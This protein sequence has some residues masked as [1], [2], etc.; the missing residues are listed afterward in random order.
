MRTIEQRRRKR[1]LAR[2][3]MFAT[4]RAFLRLQGSG[5]SSP[6][7]RIRGVALSGLATLGVLAGALAVT[8]A[9]ALAAPEAPVTEAATGETASAATL[10]GELNPLL[11]AETGWHFLYSTEPACTGGTETPAHGVAKVKAKTKEEVE[12]TGLQP[13]KTYSFCLVATNAAAESTEGNSVSFATAGVEPAL[14]GERATFGLLGPL[15]ASLE[16][17]I[18]PE[19]QET[20]YKF[21]YEAEDPTLAGTP[22]TTGEAIISPNIFEEQTAGPSDIGGGLAPNTTYYYRVVAT[23]GTGETKGPIHHF[24]TLNQEAPITRQATSI[25][26]TSAIL[27][28]ELNPGG[29]GTAAYDFSYNAGGSCEGGSTTTP[30]ETTGTAVKVSQLVALEGNTEYT[31]CL[32]GF[33]A[34]ETTETISGGS[35][36]FF[37]PKIAPEVLGESSEGVT[38]FAATLKAEVNPENQPTT[39][40]VFEYGKVVSEHSAPCSPSSVEGS[41]PQPVTASLGGLE[42]ATTYHYRVVTGNPTGKATGVK[43][44]EFKTLPTEAPTVGN[45]HA[46]EETPFAAT[47]NAEV[48]PEYQKTSCEI[49]WG[50]V[51]SEHTEKCVPPTLEGSGN[52]GVSLPVKGLKPGTIY[53]INVKAENAAHEKG[54]GTGEFKT[55]PKEAPT[56]GNLHASEETPFAATLNAEVNPEYQK[57]SCE[58]E[59]GKVVSEHK[60]KCVPPSLEGSGS[61]GVSLHVTE[62]EPNTTYHFRVI[63]KNV[64]GENPPAEAEFKTLPK[65]APTV[66]NVH[67][68]EETPFAE[69][70]NAEVNPEYQKTSCEIEYGKVVSEHKAKCVPPSLE[71]SG[72]QGVSLHVTEL[73]PNT[74]YHFR[75]IA[76]N[77]TG[78]NPPAEAEFKTLPAEAPKV[79]N[80]K[81]G[82]ESSPVLTAIDAKLEAEVN[83]DYQ[84]TTVTFE[85]SSNETAIREDKGDKVSGENIAAGIGGGQPASADLGDALR[86]NTIYYYHVV[87]ENQ[88][89]KNEDKPADGKLQSFRTLTA[90][91]IT[92]AAAQNVTSNS[93]TLS[94]TVDPEGAEKTSY[95]YAYIDQQRYE[96]A[97]GFGGGFREID[98]TFNPYAGGVSTPEVEVGN[99]DRTPLPAQPATITQLA[100]ATTY[101]YALVAVATNAPGPPAITTTVISE[102]ATFTTPT[103]PPILGATS[104]SNVTQSTA[105]ITGSVEPRGLPTRWE[106]LL[107]TTPSTLQFQAAGRSEGAG[108]Q[109]LSVGLEGLEP[110]RIYYYKFIA[111]DPDDQEAPVETPE[112]SFT[113]APGPPPPAVAAVPVLTVLGGTSSTEAKTTT[114]TPKKTAKCPKGKK[115]NG[116]GRCVKTAKGKKKKTRKGK[117]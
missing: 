29:V 11:E 18:N 108:A 84:A 96:E 82:P 27:N 90:P 47:L 75:V 99:S 109:A 61:Q 6:M 73:E 71:G 67:V 34:G 28:G 22:K 94:G 1:T 10:H 76:K 70:L 103:T 46:S 50:E 68:S 78:E 49:E 33:S 79:E 114:T 52:Q 38:P 8:A 62:L 111:L 77:V 83:P 51:V 53:H 44:E 105:T 74:T 39:S 110:A 107:G 63:A 95:H 5:A 113:T 106:L 117:K 116:H 37:T 92:T 7:S 100:S 36:T 19:N 80:E 21:E 115:R 97:V 40:C 58:I 64:T 86:P 24:T 102:G 41:S 85:Y 4:L 30:G 104:V 9:P 87:A 16:A 15:D 20:K 45:V 81:V 54:E 35:R 101:H 89:S 56:V 32:I 43:E 98:P 12:V 55:L 93:A 69:T 31:F 23:N 26:G 57:T 65:E 13:S 2:V 14:A 42:A 3:R 88:Q 59:Y 60:A 72:S 48:N 66:G 17:K 25:A 91:V 112:G